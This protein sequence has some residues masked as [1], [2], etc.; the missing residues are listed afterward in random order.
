M[1]TTGWP[2]LPKRRAAEEEE[3]GRKEGLVCLFPEQHRNCYMRNYLNSLASPDAL[4]QLHP[5]FPI[6]ASPQ[7]LQPCLW[8]CC[9]CFSFELP[10]QL[11]SF[12]LC[13]LFHLLMLQIYLHLLFLLDRPHSLPI[14][15]SRSPA[16]PGRESCGEWDGSWASSYR[17]DAAGAGWLVGCSVGPSSETGGLG[18]RKLGLCIYHQCMLVFCITF[19]PYITKFA[20]CAC[21]AS[22][23]VA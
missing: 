23:S 6:Q 9:C 17:E 18:R 1:A 4:H 12:R 20:P 2:P 22:C 15:E 19:Q 21:Q 3:A 13:A 5:P 7:L 8:L 10:Q 11:V 16:L 14:R